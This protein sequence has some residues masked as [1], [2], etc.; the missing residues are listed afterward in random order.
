MNQV[1]GHRPLQGPSWAGPSVRT[2]TR[3]YANHSGIFFLCSF[4]HFVHAWRLWDFERSPRTTIPSAVESTNSL[5][6]D[7]VPATPDGRNGVAAGF[8]VHDSSA[9]AGRAGSNSRA[10]SRAFFPEFPS[11]SPVP[12][13]RTTSFDEK[14]NRRDPLSEDVLRC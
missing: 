11:F 6:L 13:T 1:S 4:A 7:S 14:V 9:A 2:P 3:E 12:G 10:L 5:M 8:R